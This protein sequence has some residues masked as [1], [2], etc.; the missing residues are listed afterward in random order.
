ML[1]KTVYTVSSIEKQ[2]LTKE[3]R[4]FYKK[5]YEFLLI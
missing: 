4:N 5:R 1:S 2:K 3:C